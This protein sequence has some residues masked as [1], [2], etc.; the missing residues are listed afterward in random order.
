MMSTVARMLYRLGRWQTAVALAL[1]EAAVLGIVNG[2]DFPLSV[3]F[4]QRVTGHAYLDMCAFCSSAAV[5]N[6]VAGLG[7]R[8]RGLQALLLLTIDLLIPT[9]TC[10]FGLSALLVLTGKWREGRWKRWLLSLPIAAMAL[11]FAENGAIAALLLEYPQPSPVVAGL[12]GILSGLKFAAYGAMVVAI[13][14]LLVARA[15]TLARPSVR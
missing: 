8:G 6:E 14:A 2:L 9:L 12:E 7:D 3:P 11:D 4:V 10:A 13:V 5:Q 15:A 1:L